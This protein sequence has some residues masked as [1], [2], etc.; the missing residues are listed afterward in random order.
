MK[1]EAKENAKIRLKDALEFI[2]SAK[3]NFEEGRY[4]SALID[5]GDA[6]IAAND[7]FTIFFLEKV[8]SRDHQEAL[9][10]HKEAGKKI[11]ENKSDL[12]QSLLTVR[13]QKGYRSVVVSKSVAEENINNAIKFVSWVVE[14]LRKEGIEV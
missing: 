9:F 14:R 11:N 6:A 13:H 4:K 12:L 3:R 5:S 7:A 1:E 10:L 8:A 2:E